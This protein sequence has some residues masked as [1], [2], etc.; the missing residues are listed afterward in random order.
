MDKVDWRGGGGTNTGA[1]QP[2]VQCILANCSEYLQ[3]IMTGAQVI[4]GITPTVLSL[5][6]A[7][8]QEFSTLAVIGRRP[9]LATLLGLGSPCIFLGRAFEAWDP[10]K[11]LKLPKYSIL[12]VQP[13]ATVRPLV[14][15]LQYL[16][17]LC[18]IVN[19]A[20]LTWEIGLQSV[21]AMWTDMPVGPTIWILFIMPAHLAGVLCMFLR[22][23]RRFD[24]QGNLI[25]Q[26]GS[27]PSRRS[28]KQRV[29]CPG[30]IQRLWHTE[31]T[32]CIAQP[33]IDVE[34]YHKTV[35][36]I[37]LSWLISIAILVH[38]VL[39]TVVLSNTLF[40]GP[41]DALSNTGRCMLSV[42]TCRTVLMY[43]LAS[44]R[45]V[46]CKT[47]EARARRSAGD[48]VFSDGGE[49]RQTAPYDSDSGNNE[50]DI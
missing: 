8:S 14:C 46:H 7:G 30:W 16:L 18:S 13:S 44:I 9:V 17:A 21:M 6:S 45:T 19:M 47:L 5:P 50:D 35:S 10:A 49:I 20:L 42:F 11:V 37:A 32:L 48:H 23:D 15:T 38:L 3:A 31:T 29:F 36:F 41:K 34:I 22:A 24:D 40:L 1:A 12:Q 33:Y 39:G 43:E 27:K 25:K 4:L 26:I 2:V 28:L